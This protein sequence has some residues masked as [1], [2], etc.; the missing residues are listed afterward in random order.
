MPLEPSRGG[1]A[2]QAGVLNTCSLLFC[3]S[4]VSRKPCVT[5]ENV[6]RRDR[7]SMTGVEFSS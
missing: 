6:L 4:S 7:G 5:V 3:L 2:K 1:L